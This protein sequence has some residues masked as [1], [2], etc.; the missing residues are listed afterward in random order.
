M[1][2]LPLSTE[3]IVGTLQRA[4]SIAEQESGAAVAPA[5]RETFLQAAEE[6][7]IPRHAVLQALQE[8]HPGPLQQFGVGEL[9]FAPSLDGYWYPATITALD[10]GRASIRFLSGGQHVCSEAE[11]R[12]LSLVPGRRLDANLKGWG[13]WNCRVQ[14]FDADKQKVVVAE[15]FGGETHKLPVTELRLPRSVAMP[16]E[17]TAP[18]GTALVRTVATRWAI[19]A[20]AAGIGIGIALTYFL[21]FLFPWVR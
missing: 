5:D 4:R 15:S 21:P 1:Q 3:E 12:S 20:G 9:V 6:M 2:Q 17:R 19:T 7:G 8:R 18:S 13:W 16:T 10:S 11:L 14:S